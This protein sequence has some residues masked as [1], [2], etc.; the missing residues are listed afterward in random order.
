V[1]NLLEEELEVLPKLNDKLINKVLEHITKFP[2][3]YDQNDVASPCNVSKGTPCGAMGCFGG[4]AILLGVPRKQRN[5]LANKSLDLRD[6]PEED[7]RT[8]K[9]RVKTIREARKKL[10][11]LSK[12]DIGIRGTVL[13]DFRDPYDNTD[14]T[15]GY[16]FN[17]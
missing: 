9:G 14:N 7:L 3:S 2:E 13:I 11:A 17:E 8:I 4:W 6:A 15:V 10:T 12:L 16:S 1:L 5:E